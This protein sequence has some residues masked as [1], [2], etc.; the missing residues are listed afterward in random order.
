MLS[1]SSPDPLRESVLART[2]GPVPSEPVARHRAHG[3]RARAGLLPGRKPR[4][5]VR[6]GTAPAWPGKLEWQ[7]SRPNEFPAP[8]CLVGLMGL[9]GS[10]SV[11]RETRVLFLG[12][13]NG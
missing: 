7:G 10:F 11:V 12:A 8:L 3:F 9:K 6:P 1:H 5:G 2:R 13:P 4:L